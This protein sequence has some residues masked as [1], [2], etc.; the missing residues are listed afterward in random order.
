MKLRV[1]LTIFLAAFASEA[2]ANDGA[3]LIKAIRGDYALQKFRA[4]DLADEEFAKQVGFIYTV[5]SRTGEEHSHQLGGE[6]DNEVWV[7]EDGHTELVVRFDRDE[8]GEKIDG[9]GAQ[10]TDCKNM[11]SYNYYHPNEQP[12][13]HF[14]ADIF[15]WFKLGNCADDPSTSDERIE[16]YVQDLR[17]GAGYVLSQDIDYTLADGFRFKGKGQS[18]TTAIFLRALEI[19]GFDAAKLS[20]MDS[21]NVEVREGFFKAMEVGLKDMMKVPNKRLR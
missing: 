6:T 5:L 11:G 12:L 15:P 16:A 19:G 1:A 17:D 3:R 9:T 2:I 10:V 8:H 18:E 13:G 4:K 20:Q 14:A 7:H 21:M